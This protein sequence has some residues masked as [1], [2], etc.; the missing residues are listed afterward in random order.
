VRHADPAQQLF[1]K[2]A[3]SL[4]MTRDFANSRLLE[5][6]AAE[7]NADAISPKSRSAMVTAG[8]S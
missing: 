3:I 5:I 8:Q 7:P 4:G 2:S 6:S 1:E